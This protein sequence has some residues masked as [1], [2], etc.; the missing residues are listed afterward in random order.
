M[1]ITMLSNHPILLLLQSA[2][3][4]VHPLVLP[5]QQCSQRKCQQSSEKHECGT[6]ALPFDVE[7]SFARWVK[8]CTED[9]TALA[10]DVEDDDAG[11]AAGV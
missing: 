7:W 1:S 10:D 6:D 3:L 4:L 2:I 8:T 9:G 5:P 11:A